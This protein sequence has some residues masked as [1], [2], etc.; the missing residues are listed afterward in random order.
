MMLFR[1]FGV[2]FLVLASA[3]MSIDSY[4]STVERSREAARA[5]MNL[6][7]VFVRLSDI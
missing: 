2:V 5:D 7:T 6:R 3:D 1:Y 4:M